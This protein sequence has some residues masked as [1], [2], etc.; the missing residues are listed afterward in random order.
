MFEKSLVGTS[1]TRA[2][3]YFPLWWR[4]F[5]LNSALLFVHGARGPQL[6]V[7]C[8]CCLQAWAREALPQDDQR[9][10]VSPQTAD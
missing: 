10:V 3:G 2:P 7:L 5:V 1:V 9:G 4:R 6:G 8:V